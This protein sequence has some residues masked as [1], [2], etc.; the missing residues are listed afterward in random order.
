[1]MK[2]HPCKEL[3]LDAARLGRARDA[4]HLSLDCDVLAVDTEG[5]LSGSDLDTTKHPSGKS[6]CPHLTPI[7]QYPR[8][9]QFPNL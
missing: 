1:M 2:K 7:A 9:E 8:S 4:G 5:R 6:P 3:P